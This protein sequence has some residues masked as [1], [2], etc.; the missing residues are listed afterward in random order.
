MPSRPD[1]IAQ[2]ARLA[3]PPAKQS[4]QVNAQPVHASLD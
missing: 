1:K 3:V 4:V 2:K